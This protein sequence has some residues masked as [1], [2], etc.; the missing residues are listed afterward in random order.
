MDA[1]QPMNASS[2]GALSGTSGRITSW[3]DFEDRFRAAM[4]MV[5]AEPVDITMV[6]ADFGHWPLGQR[7]VM[8]ALQQWSLGSTTH[9]CQLLAASYD[10][11]ARTH[12]LWV[13]WRATWAHRVLW[14]QV[15]EDFV[16]A[17][18]PTVVLH[19]SLG[20]RLHETQHGAGVWTRD[21]GTLT[22]WLAE[23][24]VILQRSEPALPPTTL[25]L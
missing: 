10:G 1:S 2:P 24:D 13:G 25:G 22:E 5:A 21:P 8:A 23:I 4:A 19:G 12:P 6:D 9:R 16:S 17:L 11:F 15:P 3:R 14:H 20:L 7:S 18:C